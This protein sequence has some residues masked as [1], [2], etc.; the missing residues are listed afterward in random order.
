MSWWPLLRVRERVLFK[1]VLMF[2]FM[3]TPVPWSKVF[4]YRAVFNIRLSTG[5]RNHGPNLRRQ[6][7]AHK[8]LRS[9]SSSFPT[10]DW[11]SDPLVNRKLQWSQ[12]VVTRHQIG[13]QRH[14]NETHK[15][16]ERDSNAETHEI[17]TWQDE[18]YSRSDWTTGTSTRNQN[19]E[20]RMI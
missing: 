6:Y 3:N 20:N 18:D 15:H 10:S 7:V 8:A 14:D 11:V 12:Y 16:S 1:G 17:Q 13:R 19:K 5:S 2:M 9:Q 4:I